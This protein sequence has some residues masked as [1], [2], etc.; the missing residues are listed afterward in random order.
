MPVEYLKPVPLG[1]PLIAVGRECGARGRAHYYS[2][3]I[4]NQE[5]KVL[6]RSRGK[7]VEIDVHKKFPK[8]FTKDRPQRTTVR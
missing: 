5:G 1:Q 7:F 2:G 4:R 6:A 3:E 8:L